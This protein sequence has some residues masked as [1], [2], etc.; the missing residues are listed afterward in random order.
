M[1]EVWKVRLGHLELVGLLLEHSS[2]KE[3]VIETTLVVHS[4][5]NNAFDVVEPT[6]TLFFEL[7]WE[8]RQSLRDLG[9]RVARSRLRTH[10]TLQSPRKP[11]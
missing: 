7:Y 9:R 2:V 10:C 3:I 11:L 4:D 6:Y 5:T 1:F 8:P